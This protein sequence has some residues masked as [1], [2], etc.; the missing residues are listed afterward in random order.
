MLRPP[1]FCI[2]AEPLLGNNILTRV[3]A[4]VC[5]CSCAVLWCGRCGRGTVPCHRVYG[6][7]LPVNHSQGAYRAARVSVPLSLHA[8][9][10][11][12]H[13]NCL[14][15]F[16]PLLYVLLV[17]PVMHFMLAMLQ[18]DTPLSFEQLLG[19]CACPC[20]ACSKLNVFVVFMGVSPACLP[21]CLHVCFARLLPG[22]CER[23]H[24]SP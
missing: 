15:F 9:S 21:L 2:I 5:V 4:P 7:W 24:V 11:L 16:C 19:M 18:G 10:R 1:S 22:H 12:I 8:F 14:A 3:C 6:A 13:F 17:P 23:H 20:H